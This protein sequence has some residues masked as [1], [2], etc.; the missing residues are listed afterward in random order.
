MNYF[1][2][3][4]CLKKNAQFETLHTIDFISSVIYFGILISSPKRSTERI[5]LFLT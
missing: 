5:R 4:S 1:F 2:I 3:L